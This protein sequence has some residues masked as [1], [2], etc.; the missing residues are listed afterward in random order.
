MLSSLTLYL[1]EAFDVIRVF[2]LQTLVVSTSVS[3]D[4]FYTIEYS[5]L[6]LC[7][8]DAHRFLNMLVGHTVVV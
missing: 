8:R 4:N 5:N 7:G 6:M 3:S 1:S 2:D